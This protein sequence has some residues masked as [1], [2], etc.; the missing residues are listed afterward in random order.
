MSRSSRDFFLWMCLSPWGVLVLH[1]FVRPF[2]LRFGTSG[3]FF[4]VVK[5]GVRVSNLPLGSTVHLHLFLWMG[6]NT[7]HSTWQ[8][9]VPENLPPFAKTSKPSPFGFFV[10]PWAAEWSWFSPEPHEQK[11]D[12]ASRV[13]STLWESRGDSA[14]FR[15]RSYGPIEE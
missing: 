4:A 7:T 10:L 14:H 2:T 3:F 6:Q 5:L 11:T 12:T 9:G 13:G 1:P 15:R 8:P